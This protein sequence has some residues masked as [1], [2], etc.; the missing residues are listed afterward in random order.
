MTGV[1][2]KC[3]FENKNTL[4]DPCCF[5]KWA[6]GTDSEKCENCIHYFDD[7]NSEYILLPGI[8]ETEKNQESEHR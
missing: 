2:L 4:R 3:N 1:I 8:P 7:W 6:V 5:C